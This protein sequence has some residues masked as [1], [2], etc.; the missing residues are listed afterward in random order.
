V[1]G[2]ADN[3]LGDAAQQDDSLEHQ[4]ELRNMWEDHS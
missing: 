2:R 3:N 4:L 1:D